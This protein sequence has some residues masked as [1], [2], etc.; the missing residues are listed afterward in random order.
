MPQSA[1][2][3]S[4]AA[5]CDGPLAPSERLGPQAAAR[6]RQGAAAPALLLPLH[7]GAQHAVDPARALMS[8]Q[9]GR[10]AQA[11]ISRVYEAE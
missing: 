10:A 11:V 9:E 4:K 1:A 2:S 8:L 3:I 5:C 6:F 7:G